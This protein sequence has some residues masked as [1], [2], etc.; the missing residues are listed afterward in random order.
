VWGIDPEVLTPIA[1]QV[2]QWKEKGQQ[3]THKAFPKMCPAY[4]MCVPGSR[5]LAENRSSMSFVTKISRD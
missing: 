2:S 4:K 1:R 3:H 5:Y